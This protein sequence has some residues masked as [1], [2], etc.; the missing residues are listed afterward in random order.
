MHI[1]KLLLEKILKQEPELAAVTNLQKLNQ[2]A[3]VELQTQQCL[4]D[5]TSY[6]SM[7]M[8]IV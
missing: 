4:D 5:S 7:K 1:P 8:V 6:N 2:V 3:V